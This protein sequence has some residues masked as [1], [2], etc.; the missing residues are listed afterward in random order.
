[1]VK[2]VQNLYSIYIWWIKIYK[3]VSAVRVDGEL[4]ESSQVKKIAA[5]L[6]ISAAY[7]V[8]R[9]LAVCSWRDV[10]VLCRN[11][12]TYSQTFFT[13]G[14]H[15][16]LVFPYRTVCQFSN[17]DSLT[18]N[19]DGVWKNRYFPPISRFISEMIQE[20][21]IVSMECEYETVPKLPNGTIFNDP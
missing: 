4:T 21:A 14:S 12:W 13:V 15:A 2:L 6:C 16:I 20:R 10:R 9:S 17:G 11:E 7:V 5:M 19:A 8:V 18:S 1:M 3:T